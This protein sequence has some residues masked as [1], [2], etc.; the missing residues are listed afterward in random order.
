MMEFRH[1]TSGYPGRTVLSDVSLT[2]PRGK[3]TA[4]IGPNGCG[5]STLLN[6]AGGLI[7]P[8]AGEILLDGRPLP[9]YKRRELARLMALLPQSRELPRL[10]VERLAAFG[11]YPHGD[12]Q[13]AK[14]QIEESLRRAGAWELRHRELRELSGGERQRAYIAMALCQDSELL[15]LDEPTTYL[16]IGQ[17][18]QVMELV[19]DLNV[20]GRTI[21]A[22]LHDLPLAFMYSDYVALMESGKLTAFGTPDEVREPAAKAFGVKQALVTLEGREQIIFY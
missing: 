12:M 19:R 18:N 21:L 14:G 7:K 13:S 6:T 4:L 1:I 20:Q 17:K 3:I 16:D 2:V 22:V 10:T 5:K 9:S 11:R 8:S 15:L